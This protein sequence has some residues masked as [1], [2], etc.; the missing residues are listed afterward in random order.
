MHWQQQRWTPANGVYGVKT[1]EHFSPQDAQLVL[2]FAD[3]DRDTVADCLRDVVRPLYPNAHVVGCTTAGC[4]GTDG[5]TNG[6]V[7]ITAIQ[8]EA[9]RV[10]TTK[11]DID[12]KSGDFD[13]GAALGRALAGSN[14]RHAMVFGC[15]L[16]I[17][18]SQL[19]SGLE[20]AL[21]D[22]VTVTGGLAGDGT[23]FRET[24]L[25]YQDEVVPDC[26]VG[27][28]FEGDAIE[29]G[30]GSL[31]GWTPF[32]PTRRI[33]EAD[34][35]VLYGL[36]GGPALELYQNYLGD[37]AKKLPA[38]AL[39]FPLEVTAPNGGE[40]VVRTVLSIDLITG[41]MTFA[42]DIPVGGTARLMRSNSDQLID[43]AAEAGEQ[44]RAL[45]PEGDPDLTLMIS[46]VGRKMILGPRTDEEIEA[47]MEAVGEQGLVCGFYSYGELAPSAPGWPCELHNQTMTVTTFRER[48]PAGV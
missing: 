7:F 48:V 12:P 32:G 44:A 10:V 47:V 45:A 3:Q 38:S 16:T 41:G 18:G 26:V 1:S 8:F 15:G 5:L 20:S 28:G 46:C 33:T 2:I 30:H 27:V 21:P 17:N 19:V 23:R 34:A 42:G 43:G 11:I 6:A 39:L 25:V 22:A 9:T 37:F 24:F 4:I 35:N 31:G 29:V 14:L 13:T 36:D 40:T